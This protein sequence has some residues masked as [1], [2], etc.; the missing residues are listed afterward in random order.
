MAMA[1][2][3]NPVIFNRLLRACNRGIDVCL[4]I[5]NDLINNRYNG[6][7]FD[8]LIESGARLFIAEAPKLIHHKFCI[9]DDRIVIDG[10]YNWTILAE[11]NN[12]ENIVVLQNGN[13]ILSFIDAFDHL[14]RDNQQV[15]KT[16]CLY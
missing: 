2:F 13:V 15:E 9:I 3:T 12:D 6:L 7:P 4:L 14:I 11:K 5:N 10:S 1:W 16:Y 8:K